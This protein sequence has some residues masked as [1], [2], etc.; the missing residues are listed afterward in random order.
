MLKH[1]SVLTFAACLN[2]PITWA[3]EPV[4]EFSSDDPSC[5]CVAQGKRWAQGEE[6]C[7]SGI[8]MVCGMSLNM[9]TWKSSGQSCQVSSLFRAQANFTPM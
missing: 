7:I 1:L 4:P 8:R 6:A 2:I 3:A 5:A 9:T